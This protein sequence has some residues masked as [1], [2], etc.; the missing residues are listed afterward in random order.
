LDVYFFLKIK[1]LKLQ[2]AKLQ[3]T[4]KIPHFCRDAQAQASNR[5]GMIYPTEGLRRLIYT[6]FL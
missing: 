1:I 2:E 4:T 5:P 6:Y 3:Q